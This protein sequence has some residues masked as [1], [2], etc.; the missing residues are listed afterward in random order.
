MN[1]AKTK[2]VFGDPTFKPECECFDIQSKFQVPDFERFVEGVI[3][4]AAERRPD[5]AEKV[6]RQFLCQIM[7]L[8]HGI[9]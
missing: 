3:H 9:F 1:Q 4:C 5:V 7:V 8:I 6:H 2:E